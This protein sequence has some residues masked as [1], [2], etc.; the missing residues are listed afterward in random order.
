M[1]KNTDII[2]ESF[3]MLDSRNEKK[4]FTETPIKL[5]PSIFPTTDN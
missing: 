5:Q 1:P 3:L 4:N 2:Y